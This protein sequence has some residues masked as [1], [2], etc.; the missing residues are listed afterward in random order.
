[1]MHGQPHIR[2]TIRYPSGHGRGTTL[3]LRFVT[4][5]GSKK[6][7]PR[8]SCL[9]EAETLHLHRTWTEVSTSVPHFLQVRLLPNHI[10]SR[11]LLTVLCPVRRPV[12]TLDCVLF[13]DSDWAF[14]AGLRPE[15]NSRAS[16][17]VLQT[18]RH[19]ANCW[20]STRCLFLLLI[21]Y[22]ETPRDVSGPIN[23]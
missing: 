23:C 10:T 14:V 9:S 8:C 19:L 4:S 21:F 18:P 15:I 7:E 16:L 20:L 22:L 17:R 13:K 11:C 2:S 12:T 1:M 5:P 3:L 6:K